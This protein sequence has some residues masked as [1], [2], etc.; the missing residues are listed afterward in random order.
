LCL[1]PIRQGDSSDQPGVGHTVNLTTSILWIVGG[2][3]LIVLNHLVLVKL[4]TKKLYYIS[5]NETIIFFIRVFT[6]KI[7][8]KDF[9]LKNLKKL[10]TLKDLKNSVYIANRN[11]YNRTSEEMLYYRGL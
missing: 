3:G 2:I 7:N 10:F 9:D 1:E 4:R 5:W 8:F 6:V 11:K